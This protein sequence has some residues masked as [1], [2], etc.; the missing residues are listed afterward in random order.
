MIL[1]GYCYSSYTLLWRIK[2]PDKKIME[3]KIKRSERVDKWMIHKGE[4]REREGGGGGR[5]RERE[6]IR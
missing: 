2:Y 5:G 3:L 4:E 1:C 6:K